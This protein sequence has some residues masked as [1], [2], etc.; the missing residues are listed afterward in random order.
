MDEATAERIAKLERQVDVLSLAL[1]HLAFETHKE[2][3]VRERMI[4]KAPGVQL[5]PEAVLAWCDRWLPR[6]PEMWESS[7]FT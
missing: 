6:K 5:P 3:V 2:K 4:E 7:P 1:Q